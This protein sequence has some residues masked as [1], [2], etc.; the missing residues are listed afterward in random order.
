[1]PSFMRQINIISRCSTMVRNDALSDTGLKGSHYAYI[2]TL[3]RRP[4]ISQEQLSRHIY[5]N[6]SNVTRHLAQLE[7]LGY[8]ER[9]Q[10]EDDK[11]VILVY[12]TQKAIDI[13]PHVSET[14]RGWNKYLTEDFSEEE[15]E[16]FVTML[17]RITQKATSAVNKEFEES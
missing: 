7:K 5:I 4:G 17:A 15:M 8:V 13:Q 1:M 12:P 11:R 9:K 16:Q 2:L 14:V 3:C 10:S 6:K